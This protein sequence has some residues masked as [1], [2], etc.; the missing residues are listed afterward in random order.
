LIASF[1]HLKN[2]QEKIDVLKNIFNLLENNW[3]VFITCWALESK[4]NL[5]KYKS[6]KIEWSKNEFWNYDYNI[7]IWENSRFYH[8]FSI[9]E[10]EKLFMN[11]WFKILENFLFENDKNYVSIIEKK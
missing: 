6:S 11:T 7:K 10:L 5:E 1:H 2:T 4:I 3:K 8:C 9:E